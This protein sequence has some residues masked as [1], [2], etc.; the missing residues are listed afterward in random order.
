MLL[1]IVSPTYVE[2]LKS[3]S[4]LT[5]KDFALFTDFFRVDGPVG[6]IIIRLL[7]IRVIRGAGA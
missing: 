4:L 1:W 2:L 3:L 5:I 7:V 6:V